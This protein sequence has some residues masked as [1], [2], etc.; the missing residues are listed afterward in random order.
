MVSFSSPLALKMSHFVHSVVIKQ[1][2]LK[3]T[4]VSIL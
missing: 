4:Y 3:E 1:F 2:L